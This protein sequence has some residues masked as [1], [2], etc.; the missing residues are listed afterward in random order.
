MSLDSFSS[1]LEKF[2]KDKLLKFSLIFSLLLNLLLWFYLAWQIRKLPSVIPLHYN[3]YYGIDFLGPWYYLIFLVGFG[4]AL[5]VF[6]FFIALTVLTNHK[7]LS[8]F[9]LSSLVV[10]QLL[11]FMACVAIININV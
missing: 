1:I 10:I 3:I 8:Y 11:L 9:L 7:I 4:L 6:N 5:I 2:F